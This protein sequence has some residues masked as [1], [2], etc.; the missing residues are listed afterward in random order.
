MNDKMIIFDN[1]DAEMTFAQNS[2]RLSF[3][4][5][6]RELSW[7]Y[8]RIVPGLDMHAVKAPFK[9]DA[10]GKNIPSHEHMWISNVEFDGHKISGNLN[11]QPQWVRGMKEGDRVSIGLL[12]LSD[13]IYAMDGRAYGGFT[14]NAMRRSMTNR[15]L[16]QHDQAWGLDFGD[17]S[18]VVVVPNES[19]SKR[20]Y[21]LDDLIPEHPMSLNIAKRME[22][23]LK[24]NPDQFLKADQKGNSMLHY[25][26]LA[27]NLAQVKVLLANGAKREN[28]NRD[29]KTAYNLA[30]VLKW[31]KVM[32]ILK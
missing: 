25:D 16:K 1:D 32:E 13:W 14:V 18:R 6:W 30:S 22:S 11:N 23:D 27:G 9:T 4:Y 29:G 20:G 3:K 15:D 31:N 8:R 21:C 28:K 17:P 5:L 7:E 10:K 2:A 12:D 26:S 24:A 19:S